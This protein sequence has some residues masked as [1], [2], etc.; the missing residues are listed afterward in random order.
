MFCICNS[1]CGLIV[2]IP[3]LPFSDILILSLRALEPEQKLTPSLALILNP[4]DEPFRLWSN[5]NILQ[6]YKFA[7]TKSGLKNIPFVPLPLFPNALINKL[8]FTSNVVCGLVIPIPTL[9]AVSIIIEAAP[10]PDCKTNLLVLLKIVSLTTEP[11]EYWPAIVTL[12][13][14][15]FA[16]P[17]K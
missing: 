6:L 10:T 3:T 14:S 12:D 5:V 11:V 2:P 1:L 17:L 15:E 4:S 16:T 7:V 9:F 13:K 8:P